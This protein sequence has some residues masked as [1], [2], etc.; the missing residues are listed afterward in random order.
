M[1]N[2]SNNHIEPEKRKK[3]EQYHK[4]KSQKIICILVASLLIGYT[5]LENE[6]CQIGKVLKLSS[7]NIKSDLKFW[8]TLIKAKFSS[9]RYNNSIKQKNA[10]I[11][12]DITQNLLFMKDH[13]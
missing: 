2:N 4:N 1:Q 10:E 6:M 8:T 11:H 13:L 7:G 12:L 5:N 3:Y 9:S